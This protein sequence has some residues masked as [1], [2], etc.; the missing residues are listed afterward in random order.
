MR[1]SLSLPIWP[2]LNSARAF[3]SWRWALPS[4]GRGRLF[5]PPFDPPKIIEI[6]ENITAKLPG[7]HRSSGHAKKVNLDRLSLEFDYYFD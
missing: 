7:A 4:S 2:I 5:H 6:I 3:N 1:L